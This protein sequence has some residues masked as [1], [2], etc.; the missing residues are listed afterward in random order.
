MSVDVR[1][2]DD[3]FVTRTDWLCSRHSFSFGQHYDPAN[4]G[5]GLLRVHNDDVIAPGAGYDTHRHV[6]TEILTW[7]V[8]G[9]LAHQDSSGH[10]GLLTAGTIQR[11]SAGSGIT[12][13]ERNASDTE[14]LRFVQ[15]HLSADEPGAAP[16]YEQATVPIPPGTLVTVASGRSDRPGAVRVNNQHAALHVARLGAGDAVT[17]PDAPCLHVYVVT[18]AAELEAAGSLA[19]GDA[20]RLDGE[21]PGTLTGTAPGTEVLVWE[22]S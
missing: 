7:V 9:R 8:E 22:M 13:S 19:E 10:A 17:L 5:H 15:M 16:S 12:H 20:A 4:V 3:R 1:R 6:G 18:G 21:G 14:P 2:A 11:T